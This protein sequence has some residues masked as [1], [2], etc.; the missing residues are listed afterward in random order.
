MPTAETK[1]TTWTNA[2]AS[3]S[4]FAISVGISLFTAAY[5]KAVDPL[6]GSVATA[7]YIN[8]VV[9][10][11]TV[12]AIILPKLSRSLL[13]PSIAILVQ[14][15]PHTTY[16]VSVFAARNGDP[17]LGSLVTHATVLAPVI[18]LA[19]SLATSID[20][21]LAT[22][23]LAANALQ[24]RP[25]I[26][27]VARHLSLDTH[28]DVV[29]LMLGSLASLVWTLEKLGASRLSTRAASASNTIAITRKFWAMSIPLIYFLFPALWSPT[30]SGSGIFPYR[31]QDFPL[32]I[33]S[34]KDSVTGV[35]VVGELLPPNAEV[36]DP[37]TTH[38]IR[39]LRASHSLLGGV[40]IGPHVPSLHGAPSRTD[41]AGTPLGDSIYSTFVLQDAARLI[42]NNLQGDGGEGENALIIGL[43][44]GISADAFIRHRIN[45]T[46]VEIDPAVYDA[47]R[48]YF[49]L[50]Y[51]G[52]DRVFLE[53]ARNWVY[54]RRAAMQSENLSTFDIVIHDCFSGGGVPQ[55]L[56]SVEFWNDLKSIMK[57][58]GV[59]A[60]NFAGR[61]GSQ[62][63]RAVVTT[64]LR[65]F[66]Q[67]RAFHDLPNPIPEDQFYS[68]FLNMVFFCSPSSYP[69]TFRPA[70]DAD[71]LHSYLRRDILSS[72]DKRE[73][74]VSQLK[75]TD[76]WSR[77]TEERFVLT[78]INNTLNAWQREEA[79]EHWK[80]MRKI[81]PDIVWETY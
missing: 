57:P 75:G 76:V 66:G 5:E 26:L 14:V 67:C 68:T 21:T 59:V 64:L 35:V 56:F 13:L 2:K 3:L 32:R 70:V 22:I 20:S 48:K 47:A 7:E 36:V 55:H 81:L 61:F 10:G 52:D 8:Y 74:S 53:D 12:L 77:D 60:V 38:Y 80:L 51:P 30:L 43:G 62:S 16:W 69:L 72:L 63:T 46:I 4:I 9:H 11:S 23:A 45:T 41:Q 24:L 40:W 6:F 33:L 65:V 44:V 54:K 50:V 34:S 58:N 27:L 15:A 31:S 19:V 1:A 37:T 73:L 28:K 78:D 42:M 71:Y 29:F 39:Y 17:V 49:G 18:Y 25:L 79:L